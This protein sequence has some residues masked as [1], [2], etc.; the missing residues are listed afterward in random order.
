MARLQQQASGKRRAK[1]KLLSR[2]ESKKLRQFIFDDP[3]FINYKLETNFK[4]KK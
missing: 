4:N 1:E 3:R 2:D